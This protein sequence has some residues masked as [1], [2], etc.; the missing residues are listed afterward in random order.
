MIR[1]VNGST[2][3]FLGDLNRIQAVNDR[4]QRQ[5]SSGLQVEVP[6][7]APDE[8]RGILQMRAE[9]QQNTQIQTNLTTVK[10]DVTTGDSA[11]Q[12]AVTA[13]DR[14][15]TLGTAGAGDTSTAAQRATM[16]QEV[17]GLLETLVG[18]SRSSVAG[19]FIFSGDQ[20]ASPAYETDAT[21]PTGVRRLLVTGGSTRQVQGVDGGSFPVALT[22]Q[23]VFDNR[24]A[25]DSVAPDN[26]FAA[27]NGLKVAL[28]NNDTPGIQT[29][30][31]NLQA[32]ADHLNA[33][34]GFYGV[35]ENRIQDALDN[36]AK[37]QTQEKTS[38]GALVD[39]D[40][41]AATTELALSSTHQQAALAA[42]AK[43]PQ[44]SLFNFLA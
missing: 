37:M 11:V 42:R 3:Q 36:A 22:A 7:D 32:A 5:I 17:G 33:Q 2:D 4:A 38:L 39:T 13:L 15:R 34:L 26:V 10:A 14:V 6:S 23:N 19:R 28:Q 27:V 21:S 25:D 40:L 31:N 1:N 44:T 18:L 12:S 30:L 16:A 43:M 24:N 29:A 35:T 9:I 20:P 41:A 8:I